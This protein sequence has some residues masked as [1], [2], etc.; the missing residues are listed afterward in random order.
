[1]TPFWRALASVLVG[2]A[3]WPTATHAAPPVLDTPPV[4]RAVAPTYP[5]VAA[6]A[7]V[8]GYV[9][10]DVEVDSTGAVATAKI[11]RTPALLQEEPLRAAQLWRFEPDRD[12]PKRTV[13]L[14][15]VFDL[16][17]D[18]P[19]EGDLYPAFA[20]PYIVEVRAQC[21]RRCEMLEKQRATAFMGLAR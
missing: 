20:P 15:F 5:R 9:L 2:I 17:V 8:I 6:D 19:S 12:K 21:K 14:T 3:A 10:V 7:S 18:P 1:M 13:R 4:V 11:V 16:V